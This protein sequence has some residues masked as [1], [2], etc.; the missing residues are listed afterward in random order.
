MNVDHLPRAGG[1]VEPVDV[2][3]QGP[4]PFE[5][6]L[7]LGHD[8]VGPVEPRPPA[9]G[10]DLSQ[11]GELSPGVFGYMADRVKPTQLP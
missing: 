6:V 9:G 3:G 2:L 7:D 1:A 11:V 8:L 10:L 5:V 4:D